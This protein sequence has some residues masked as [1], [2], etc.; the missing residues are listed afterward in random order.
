MSDVKGK[1]T[2]D[3][4]GRKKIGRPSSF[5]QEVADDIC[6]LLA[7]GESL[8]KICERPG[9]PA[10]SSVFKWLNEN[11]QFS[12]QY[13]RAREDQADFLLEEMLEISDL[14][15]PEDVSVA[16][17]RVDARKWYITKVAPKKYGD[18]VTQEITGVNGAPIEQK[19][20]MDLSRLSVDELKL[21]RELKSKATGCN[22]SSKE[23]D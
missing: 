4:V 18:K 17:L 1:S 19:I 8:R 21:L 5:M 16:K 11:Q 20:S 13:A 12:E 23:L 15:T 2:S 14:A 6:L 3:G 22:D 9:M 7:Q 10:I